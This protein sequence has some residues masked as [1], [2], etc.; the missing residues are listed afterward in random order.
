MAHRRCMKRLLLLLLLS[1]P[2]FAEAPRSEI[3]RLNKQMTAALESGDGA[4]VARLYA[5]DA[6]I[7]GPKRREI[8]GREAIDRYWTGIH[9]AK[10]TLEVREVGGSA[11]DAYEIGVSTLA[12][13][14]GEKEG[15]YTCDF[16]VI[17]RR[18]AS[19]KLRIHLDLYN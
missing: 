18:D 13:K 14:D 12:W 5:D 6:R 15:S 9:N 4:G 17:W 3:E 2:A 8:R 1:L 7:V 11:D 10:W 19:G 16:V